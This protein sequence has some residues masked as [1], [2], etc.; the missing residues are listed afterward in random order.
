MRKVLPI[1]IDTCTKVYNSTAF[2]L[3]ILE[4]KKSH[5]GSFIINRYIQ[6]VYDRNDNGFLNYYEDKPYYFWNC[7][8]TKSKRKIH[9]RKN[10]LQ[11]YIE[12]QID[13][14]F[15][16]VSYFNEY[17]IPQRL[18]FE[19][20]N[21][22]HDN[23]IYGYDNTHFYVLGYDNKRFYSSIKVSKEK[24]CKSFFSYERASDDRD[25]SNFIFCI[26]PKDSFEENIQIAS[27]KNSIQNYLNCIDPQENLNVEV[28]ANSIFGLNAFLHFFEE[29]K[30]KNYVDFRFLRLFF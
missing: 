7:F 14:G 10:N 13:K 24:I 11:D 1:I 2:P 20:Y 27:I 8:Y 29:I 18:S 26:K 21:F 6:V 4:C 28:Y 15:Y 12:S 19:K 16:I 3:S 23:M 25:L 5:F 22:L 17:Y 9:F 30:K